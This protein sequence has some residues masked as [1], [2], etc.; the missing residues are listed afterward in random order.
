VLNVVAIDEHRPFTPTSAGMSL[1]MSRSTHHDAEGK[2]D[3]KRD[4]P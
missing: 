1:S 4:H 2:A 3:L